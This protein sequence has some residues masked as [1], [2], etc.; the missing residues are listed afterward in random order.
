VPIVA[1]NA[2][3]RAV[4]DR[5]ADPA[6]RGALSVHAALPGTLRSQVDAYEAADEQR[7]R[8]HL[9]DP[10]G[11]ADAPGVWVT[12]GPAERI[13][14]KAAVTAALLERVRSTDGPT[15]AEIDV[16]APGNPVLIPAGVAPSVP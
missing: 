2:V 14:D 11:N 4:G 3:P 12:V 5:I 13:A 1:P 9:R 15:V 6:V 16:R 10:A 8:L 7:L